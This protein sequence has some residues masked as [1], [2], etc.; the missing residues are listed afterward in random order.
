M[1][2]PK[3][4]LVLM[5][6]LLLGLSTL[7]A[8][9]NDPAE[10]MRRFRERQR[11]F[12]KTLENWKGNFAQNC[13]YFGKPPSTPE[14]LKPKDPEPVI[15]TDPKKCSADQIIGSD[16]KCACKTPGHVA[17][18]L[19]NCVPPKVPVEDPCA[20]GKKCEICQEKNG[21][22]LCKKCD[23]NSA[24]C[25]L[26]LNKNGQQVKCVEC[27]GRNCCVS[28]LSNP[29][30]KLCGVFPAEEEPGKVGPEPNKD[31]VPP[32]IVS[33]KDPTKLSAMNLML[34]SR[35]LSLTLLTE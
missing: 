17:N 27:D 32:T 19:G 22:E 21:K 12:D 4:L 1:V 26:C 23:K 14:T 3:Q 35:K 9:P 2:K 33:K 13:P 15:P 16:G 28:K 34:K 8:D 31:P 6:V 20:A 10:A 30:S 25:Q 11:G 18:S 29:E 24:N 7:T 5:I